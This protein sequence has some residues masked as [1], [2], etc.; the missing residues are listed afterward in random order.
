[1]TFTYTDPAGIRRDAIRLLTGDTY[2]GQILLQDEE[3]DFVLGVWGEHGDYTVAAYA[4]ETIAAKFAR[5]VDISADSQSVAANVLQEKYLRLAE[6]LRSQSA[7]S[8]PGE[9]YIGGLSEYDTV[10]A[11]ESSPAFGTGMHDNPSAGQQDYGDYGPTWTDDSAE[12][13]GRGNHA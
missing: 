7:G 5:E 10:K 8:Y 1:M 11:W 9:I 13:W 6:R 2:P 12:Q 4:A 3:Y